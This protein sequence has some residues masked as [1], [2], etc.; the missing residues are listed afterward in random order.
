LDGDGEDQA[1][2]AADTGIL[3]YT[4][5]GLSEGPHTFVVEASDKAG[6]RMNPPLSKN[7]TVNLQPDA[8]PPV[9]SGLLP[10]DGNTLKVSRPKL[11]AQIKDVQSGV[12][13]ADVRMTLDG[14]DLQVYYDSSNGWAYALP[15]SALSVGSHTF[16]VNAKDK[17]GNV[18]EG[19]SVTFTVV[20]FA[21]PA[22]S[23][24]FSFSVTSDSHATDFTP[25]FFDKI[26]N[27]DSELVIQNGDLVDN[28]TAAQWATGRNQIALLT[29]PYMISPGNHEA[30]N[31]SLAN[32][33]T[34]FGDP[35]YSFEYGNTLFISLNS[36]LGQSISGS[37]PTQ[38]HYLQRVLDE[39]T[40]PNVVIFTHNTTR[41]TFGTAHQMLESDADRLEK[42]LGDYK[43]ANPEKSVNAIFG[44]LHVAQSWVKVGVTY[45][46]SGD[47]ALK[48][49]V[50]PENGGFLSYTQF[51][52][53]GTN[54]THKF[55]PLTQKIAVMDD[56]IQ[57]NGKLILPQ[58][59]KRT[60]NV[61]GD[62]SA[63]TAD[64]LVNLSRFAD[65]DKKFTS[66]DNGVV[67]VSE[68]GELS[69]NQA[70]TAEV[71]ITVSGVT[72]IL[73]VEVVDQTEVV[74]IRMTL[75]PNQ[76]SLNGNEKLVFGVTGYDVFGNTFAIDSSKVNWSVTEGIGQVNNGEFTAAE[77]AQD[78]T[79]TVVAEFNGMKAQATIQVNKTV[80]PIEGRT[81]PAVPT[82]LH[83][84]AGNRSVTLF[85]D[86][87]TDEDLKGYWIYDGSDTP[88]FV[89]KG[90]TSKTIVNLEAGR[91]YV[92]RIAAEDQ[93][94][95]LSA[96]SDPVQSVPAGVDAGQDLTSPVW[97]NGELKAA[98]VTDTGLRLEWTPAEDDTAVEAYRIYMDDRM[99]TTV[100]GSTYVYEVTGLASGRLYTFRVEAGDKAN[101]WSTEGLTLQ[102]R[103]TY[104]SN[105]NSSA[106][107]PSAPAM[108]QTGL[109]EP[110]SEE[111]TVQHGI[112]KLDIPNG[113]EGVALPLNVA[114]RIGQQSSL[115]L[116]SGELR[117]SI[118][119]SV[120]A[121]A[122][123]LLPLGETDG[124]IEVKMKS[125]S[126]APNLELTA[127]GQ[128]YELTIEA[129]TKNGDASRLSQ[130]ST[131]ITIH[132]SAPKVKNPQLAGIYYISPDGEYTLIGGTYEEGGY[133]AEL[134]H[135][136]TYGVF[137]YTKTYQDVPATHWAFSI[138]QELSFKGIAEGMTD[139][140]FA[141]DNNVTRAEF[142]A[143]LV[144]ALGGK[145][146]ASGS[147]FEDVKSGDW[148]AAAV[149]A[150]Y[151][152]GLVQGTSNNRF[153]PNRFIT[154]EEMAAMIVRA[155]EKK[156][157]TKLAEGK[158]DFQ[159]GNQISE[160]A[161]Q[162]VNQAVALKLIEGRGNGLFVP[163]GFATRAESAKLILLC[164]QQK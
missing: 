160:W 41:D 28:D 137:E 130:F 35:T 95:N 159:D 158:S 68:G 19:K 71:T 135:F 89:D 132:I 53:D 57:N 70:G 153:E 43:A 117:M 13:V 2:F 16:A 33:F 150:A 125:V 99:L 54:V 60:L 39:N 131:P 62:F 52:V 73:P 77:L 116:K 15:D 30:F 105:S 49:Y 63:V 32:Y 96:Q 119:S 127:G 143:L 141:P 21:Q 27:D 146:E 61:Y 93:S 4:A 14:Q 92:F 106:V 104:A 24:K 9:I 148:Y 154:R 18:A 66:S 90:I 149:R 136:S 23:D 45:T 55:L 42:I 134:S 56:A 163:K 20:D 78:T 37:D 31:G 10:L 6:N 64:Y 156:T 144:R 65:V 82:G 111:L 51:K 98:N 74:P 114:E 118:P 140:T 147:S 142:A 133:T 47:E 138:I 97:I 157:G 80:K 38:F 46:I 115:I 7:V 120:L 100:S 3:T 83:A 36:A 29:K 69:A 110:K 139:K 48:K 91:A 108:K 22:N 67:S 126:A 85:W 34:Y 123:K 112:V 58:G 88:V 5:K 161:M 162:A 155:I 87:N 103:T 107:V 81:P 151:G 129:V 17:A 11:S 122:A 145:A 72:T 101:N 44:H 94:G 75:S 50:T 26:N 164:M 25:L 84:N 40:K 124:R 121:S 79:G 86:A 113:T 109:Y 76:D 59:V 128:T 1:H 8:D 152:M 102:V 12:D